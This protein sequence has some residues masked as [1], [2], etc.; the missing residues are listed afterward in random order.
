MVLCRTFYKTYNSGF[1]S[2]KKKIKA[3][4]IYFAI[5]FSIVQINTKY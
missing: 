3:N 2:T 5:P 4:L 1:N